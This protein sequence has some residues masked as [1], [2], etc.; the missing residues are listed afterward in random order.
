MY[1]SDDYNVYYILKLLLYYLIIPFFKY[2]CKMASV[3][4]IA[5]NW[6]VFPGEDYGESKAGHIYQHSET[7][8]ALPGSTHEA[9]SLV[10]AYNYRLC[11]TDSAENSVPW[12]EPENYIPEDYA[13]IYDFIEQRK[14][15]P[16]HPR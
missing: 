3:F 9:D 6:N 13:V 5:E 4:N 11:L 2:K 8:L 1:L 14:G 15:S 10:Q 7:L 12:P 16:R